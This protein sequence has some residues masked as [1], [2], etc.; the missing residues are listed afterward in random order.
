MGHNMRVPLV[1]GTIACIIDVLEKQRRV[2]AVVEKREGDGMFWL[3]IVKRHTVMKTFF[4]LLY[5][6]GIVYNHLFAA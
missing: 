4:P 3:L 6:V 1:R 2:V 5:C